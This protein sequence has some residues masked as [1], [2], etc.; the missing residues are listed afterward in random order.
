M[1]TPCAGLAGQGRVFGFAVGVHQAA[2]CRVGYGPALFFAG[3]A[4]AR[5]P[6]FRVYAGLAMGRAWFVLDIGRVQTGL[7]LGLSW[8]GPVF[9]RPWS[10]QAMCRACLGLAMGRPWR[11]LS[12]GRP[13]LGWP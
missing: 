7:T 13:W 12:V 4:W 3:R 8:I 1:G 10:E 5:L 2:T 6:I 11:I 9:G